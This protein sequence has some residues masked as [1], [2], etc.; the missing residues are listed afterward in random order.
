MLASKSKL[1]RK[2]KNFIGLLIAYIVIFSFFSVFGK[3]F[4]SIDNIL[5]VLRLM[6]ITG[7]IGIGMTF[8]II[9]GEIDL[10]VG[11]LVAVSGMVFGQFVVL[12]KWNMVLA[13]VCTLFVGGLSGTLVGFLRNRYKIPAF[14][15]TL[16]LQLM[17][18]GLAFIIYPMS[19]SPYPQ[20]FQNFANGYVGFIPNLVIIVIVLYILGH[21]VLNKT[22]LGRH[23]FSVGSSELAARYS[24]INV[25]KVR[26]LVFLITGVL[27]SFAGILMASNQMSSLPNIAK[28]YELTIIAGVIVGGASLAGGS[29]SLAGTFLGMLMVHTIINGMVL[30]GLS[31]NM[32]YIIQG[33]I[34]VGAV[35][36][37]AV[38]T[39]GVKGIS[40]D[41]S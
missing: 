31:S 7:L 23:I 20:S 13:G 5:S 14:I 8:V 40:K 18:R 17:M 10:S 3:N 38:N 19:L 36:L 21:I 25:E 4:L 35:L 30:M 9:T 28:N 2:N 34:I 1:F 39:Y 16:S 11:A 22:K 41:I 32:Q 12:W 27:A 6:A 29:G 15:S 24:G 33:V 37:N 26:I